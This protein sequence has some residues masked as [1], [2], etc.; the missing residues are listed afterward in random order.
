MKGKDSAENRGYAF[1]TYRNKELSSK[2]I[3]DLNGTEFK[4]SIPMPF[5]FFFFNHVVHH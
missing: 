5:F 4:A 2:A 1:I 3:K